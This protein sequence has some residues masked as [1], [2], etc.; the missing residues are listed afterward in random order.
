M[1]EIVLFDFYFDSSMTPTAVEWGDFAKKKTYS[2]WTAEE[3][4]LAKVYRLVSTLGRVRDLSSKEVDCL[5][6]PKSTKQTKT[7]QKLDEQ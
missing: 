5:L 1:I 6:W 3:R 2:P 4:I 7:K